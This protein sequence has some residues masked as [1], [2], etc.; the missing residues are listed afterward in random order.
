MAEVW[1]VPTWVFFHTIAARINETFLKQNSNNILS[2]IK[3]ICANL[4][5]PYCRTHATTFMN[6]VTIEHINTKKRFIH[7]FFAFHNQVNN[8]LHKPTYKEEDLEKYK[9][10]QL[11]IIYKSFI[12]GFMK[13]YSRTL[14]AGTLSQDRIRHAAGR[15]VNQW[16]KKHWSSLQGF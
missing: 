8:R 12:Y 3:L 7:F 15:T 5:C 16:V 9:R 13:K 10:A 6:A 2:I 4:P 11:D 14:Y 1:A